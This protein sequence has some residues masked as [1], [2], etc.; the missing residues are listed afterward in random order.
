MEVV[1]VAALILLVEGL[2]TTPAC[3]APPPGGSTRQEG[4]EPRQVTSSPE[5]LGKVTWPHRGSGRAGTLRPG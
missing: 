1:T 4:E 5:E 3:Q 2:A